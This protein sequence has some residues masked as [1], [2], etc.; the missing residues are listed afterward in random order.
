MS[1]NQSLDR[2]SSYYPLTPKHKTTPAPLTV[3]SFQICEYYY[4][5]MLWDKL[6]FN[7]SSLVHVFINR[8]QIMSRY[9]CTSVIV[10]SHFGNFCLSIMLAVRVQIS[11][12]AEMKW[13]WH[14]SPCFTEVIIQLNITVPMDI[15]P[16]TLI[17][18]GGE[19][20]HCRPSLPSLP[21]SSFSMS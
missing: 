19:G 17:E 4:C 2:Q 6:C 18:R 5:W 13:V 15:Q 7:L 16:R 21:P 9:G 1:A 10:P 3:T 14:P 12:Q 20:E 8:W 11:C